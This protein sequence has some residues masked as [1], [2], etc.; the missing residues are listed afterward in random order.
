MSN[1]PMTR[2]ELANEN[3]KLREILFKIVDLTCTA[4]TVTDFTDCHG[5]M[6]EKY[7]Y[8]DESGEP[9]CKGCINGSNREV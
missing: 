3:E 4:L 9:T 1:E 2:T 7:D 5:C 8:Y 6:W